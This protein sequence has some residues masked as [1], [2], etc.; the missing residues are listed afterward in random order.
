MLWSKSSQFCI[1]VQKSSIIRIDWFHLVCIWFYCISGAFE[2][3]A[4]GYIT[5]AV[6]T[7]DW[8]FIWIKA[9]VLTKLY[10]IVFFSSG[11]F[12]NLF[13]QLSIPGISR[14][15]VKYPEKSIFFFRSVFKSF[16]AKSFSIPGNTWD[17]TWK[18]VP[19]WF[20]RTS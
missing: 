6:F 3:T 11:P 13:L 17:D 19:R 8:G 2:S 15:F 7:I 14:Y 18:S 9:P 20:H 4:P 12:S 5:S 10:R 16:F 1:M